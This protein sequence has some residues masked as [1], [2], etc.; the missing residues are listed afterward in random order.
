MSLCTI[1]HW[2][3]ILLVLC[4]HILNNSQHNLRLGFEYLHLLCLS[5]FLSYSMDW[6][7]NIT[8]QARGGIE[9]DVLESYCWMY[10]TWNIPREYKGACSGGDQD[11]DTYTIMY[12]SYYQ[13]V[14]LYLIFLAILFYLPRMFWLM[15]EGGIMK[16]F[17]KGTTTRFAL[18]YFSCQVSQQDSHYKLIIICITRFVEDADEKK[19]KLVRFFYKNIHNK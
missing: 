16:F 8:F 15:M 6:I 3:S 4:S 10:S 2:I 13:W 17:G 14:P 7:F 9:L 11:D 5:S 18:N 12:N 19:E 1:E